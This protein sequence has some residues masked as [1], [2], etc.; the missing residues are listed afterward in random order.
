MP[1]MK[2]FITIALMFFVAMGINAQLLYKN[3]DDMIITEGISVSVKGTVENDAGKIDVDALS[4]S[5]Q[6]LIQGDFINNDVA[7][8]NGYYRVLGDWINNDTFND[9]TGTV[10]LEG[11]N[12]TL[13]GSATTT[14]NNLTLDGSGLKTQSIDQYCTGILSLNDVELQTE[15]YGFYVENSDVNA[16]TYDSG[17]VSSLNGGFLSRNTNSSATYVFPVGSSIGTTRYR[18]AVITPEDA[19]VNTYTVRMA[20]T[21]ATSEGFDLDSLGN[22]ICQVN[23]LF[24][25]QIERTAGTSAIDLSIYYDDSAD[26]SH[27]GIVNWATPS[28][29]WEIIPGSTTNSGTPLYQAIATGWNDFSGIPYALYLSIP[30]A[31]IIDPGDFCSNDS[32]EDLTAES[33]G[34]MWSGNGITDTDNGTFDPSVAGVGTSTITYEVTVSGCTDTDDIDIEVF[35]SPDVTITD[36]GDF[37][38]DDG[39]ANLTA[40][41]PDGTWSG[42]GITD[43]SAGTFDPSVAGAGI[44]TITYEVTE[45]GCTGTDDIDIEVYEASDVTID[46]AGLF[47]YDNFTVQLEAANTGGIWTGTFVDDNGIFDVGAAG[48]GT[49]LVSYEISGTCGDT[50]TQEI[51]VYPTDFVVDYEIA[52][53]YCIGGNNGYIKFDVTG[54]TSPYTYQWE[55]GTSDTSFI[56][57]LSAGTYNFTISDY[58]GCNVEVSEII[59]ND[60]YKNCI[61]IPD[62]F[63][64]NDD[65]VND[66][67]IIENLEYYP[68]AIVKVYNRWGQL[69]YEGGAGIEPWNGTYKN[70]PVPTGAYLFYIIN[71]HD[72]L[73]NIVGTVTVI[74]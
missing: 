28:G 71:P 62:A 61:E 74:R 23:P 69:L 30:D 33:S 42:G 54:G 25:H 15:T 29:Q 64:P 11:D 72:K 58:H 41:P 48:A 17:F 19:T 45:S 32:P 3:G 37:C 51:T 9:A 10:F 56:M 34:G 36:P 38:S 14:F 40:S 7:G 24:Y 13:G 8:G 68:Q 39:P 5:S 44:S 50:A 57:N 12:Q 6:L 46:S 27:D 47:C 21:S 59:I 35:E 1:V 20:N 26:G 70:R 67:W 65:G 31:T 53:P 55:Y 18:P 16:I 66:T 22:G 52:D 63:T 43:S 4:G 73:D 49:H 60:G 2:Y